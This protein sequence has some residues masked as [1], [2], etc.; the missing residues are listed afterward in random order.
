MRNSYS[1][2]EKA[3]LITEI[4]E[5]ST[6]RVVTTSLLK[7]P[8]HLVVHDNLKTSKKYSERSVQNLQSLPQLSVLC[9]LGHCTI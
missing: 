2:L 1:R 5:Y 7:A 9:A 4:R 6:Y 8:R 3:Y